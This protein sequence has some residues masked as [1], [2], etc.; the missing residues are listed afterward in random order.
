MADDMR[1]KSDHFAPA[2]PLDD[3]TKILNRHHAARE[4]V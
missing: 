2:M 4:R 1:G 3:L